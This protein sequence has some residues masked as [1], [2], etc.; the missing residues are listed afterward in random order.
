MMKSSNLE[1]F[2]FDL[3]GVIIDSE[4]YRDKVTS[5]LV[6]SFGFKY[7]RDKLKPLMSGK[8]SLECMKILTQAYPLN[9]TSEELESIR[10]KK[11]E[12]LYRKEIPFIEG[13]L[14]LFLE[15]NRRFHVP[16]AVATACDKEY[17]NLIDSR[18]NITKLFQGHVYSSDIVEN[19]KPSPDIFIY[20]A[21]QI[22][23]N[24][25]R[26][27]VFEDSPFGIVAGLKAGS[28]VIAITRTF[29][30]EVLLEKSG[31]LT[32]KKTDKNKLLFIPDYTN[33]AGR[34]YSFIENKIKE[35]EN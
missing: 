24:P 6:S 14:E 1:G 33:S 10:R 28:R 15:L 18:L 2:L 16:S 19:H 11:I 8:P 4:L 3:D 30:K 9:T 29:S 17:Y 31:E 35:L 32:G 27:I 23:A 7:D 34:I 25:S 20:A 12:Q 26:C 22:R 13:F 5:N 21:K